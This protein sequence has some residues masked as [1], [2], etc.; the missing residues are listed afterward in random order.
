VIVFLLHRRR[1][2]RK[3]SSSMKK[4]QE[5]FQNTYKKAE[6]KML[7]EHRNLNYRNHSELSPD[8]PK[9]AIDVALDELSYADEY[10][11]E[12]FHD[13]EGGVGTGGRSDGEENGDG[14]DEF[15]LDSNLL[16]R[17]N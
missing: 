4:Q 14:K 1:R 16:Q 7:K 9:D 17:M 5:I 15:V 8:R 2:Q 6:Q 13:E 11:D 10:T 3:P 12:S